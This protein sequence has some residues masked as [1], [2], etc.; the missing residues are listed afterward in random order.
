MALISRISHRSE[1]SI[2]KRCCCTEAHVHWG[3]SRQTTGIRLPHARRKRQFLH[4]PAAP[5]ILHV[6]VFSLSHS[7]DLVRIKFS[8]FGEQ[9][10]LVCGRRVVMWHTSQRAVRCPER[11]DVWEEG[12]F[13]AVDSDFSPVHLSRG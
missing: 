7:V 6:V 12:A 4:I 2:K 10:Q 3:R 11:E 1:G 9:L 8:V 5:P 13:S